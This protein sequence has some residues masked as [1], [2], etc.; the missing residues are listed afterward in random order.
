[1]HALANIDDDDAQ[2]KC[3]SLRAQGIRAAGVAAAHGANVDAA[4][5]LTDDHCAHERTDEIADQEFDAKLEHAISVLRD[6]WSP[7]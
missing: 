1:V 7:L 2:G 4:T 3:N 5:Q 6:D